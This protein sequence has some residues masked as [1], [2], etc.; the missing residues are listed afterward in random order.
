MGRK[1]IANP[2]T[3]HISIVTTED[4][5]R[6]FRA[7]GLVGDKA[8]DA[9]LYFLENDNK[10]MQINKIMFLSRINEIEKQLKELEYEKLALETELN[11]INNNS[12]KY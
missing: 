1:R 10:K 3:R 6:R 2:K 7:L 8:I 9:L 11:Q 12:E 5:Y 4:K